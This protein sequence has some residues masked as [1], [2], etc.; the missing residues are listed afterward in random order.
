MPWKECSVMDERLRFVAKLL[1]GESMTGLCR[2]FGISRKTGYKIFARYKDQGAEA[3]CDRSRRPVR[4]ANQL[5]AQIES[6][7]VCQREPKIPQIW[8][9][10]IPHPGYASASSVRTRPAFNFSFSR[11][12]LPRMLSVTA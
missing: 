11:Y 8:E 4:Y 6:L 1:D 3:L 9:S 5:P 7:I 2:E 10:K 12:E